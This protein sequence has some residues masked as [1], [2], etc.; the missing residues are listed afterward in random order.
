[1]KRLIQPGDHEITPII[2]Q[3]RIINQV[4]KPSRE[5]LSASGRI[6]RDLF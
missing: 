3:I 2:R 1:M 4:S 5:T 6:A